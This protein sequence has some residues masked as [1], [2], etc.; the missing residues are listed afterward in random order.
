MA[1]DLG[2]HKICKTIVTL[3]RDKHYTLAI[4]KGVV[5]D[6]NYQTKIRH[7]F[8]IYSLMRRKKIDSR[9]VLGVKVIHSNPRGPSALYLNMYECHRPQ[10]HFCI[11]IKNRNI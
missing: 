8:K 11:A 2:K 10:V 1:F 6:R 4:D 7:C 3:R 9:P 5:W